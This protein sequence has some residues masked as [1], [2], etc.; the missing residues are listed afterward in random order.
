M[1]YYELDQKEQKILDSAEA[2]EFVSIKNEKQARQELVTA[3]KN[4]GNKT[5]NINIRVSERVLYK[6]KARA[7]REGIPYQTL[8]SSILHQNVH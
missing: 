1:K 5:R 3:A 8:V 4:T 6:L 2:G 7:L